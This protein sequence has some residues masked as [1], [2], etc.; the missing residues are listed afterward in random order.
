MER[1]QPDSVLEVSEGF[2]LVPPQ[3][4]K[5]LKNRNGELTTFKVCGKV[6]I[7]PWGNLNAKDAQ[8]D[9]GENN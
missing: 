9:E 7:L 2:F 1:K 4:V 8:M 3:M 6:F 5:L